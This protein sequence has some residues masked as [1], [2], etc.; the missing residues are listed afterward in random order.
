MLQNLVHFGTLSQRIKDTLMHVLLS[1]LRM[2]SAGADMFHLSSN[3]SIIFYLLLVALTPVP[4]LSFP[5]VEF[6]TLMEARE[7]LQARRIIRSI[8]GQLKTTGLIRVRVDSTMDRKCDLFMS[9]SSREP[10]MSCHV[11][12]CCCA[13]S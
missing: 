9:R 7:P 1:L 13:A 2:V 3:V 12:I 5:G 6:G 10:V 8:W 4:G 11:I